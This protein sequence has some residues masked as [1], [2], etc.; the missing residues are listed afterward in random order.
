VLSVGLFEA[1]NYGDF[2]LASGS[3]LQW[4]HEAILNA[5]EPSACDL[6]TDFGIDETG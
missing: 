3:C 1:G 2:S 6:A 4:Q 5:E